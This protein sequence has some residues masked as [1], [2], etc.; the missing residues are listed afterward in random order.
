MINVVCGENIY[1]ASQG[2]TTKAFP[3]KKTCSVHRDRGRAQG[4]PAGARSMETEASFP[5]RKISPLSAF[6]GSLA[7]LRR[8]SVPPPSH[9]FYHPTI[10]TI[11]EMP[12]FIYLMETVP[13]KPTPPISPKLPAGTLDRAVSAGWQKGCSWYLRTL[14]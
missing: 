4:H 6:P 9:P 1:K 3:V 5:D 12:A 7:L 14:N 2:G 8:G 11:R 13:L 10:L